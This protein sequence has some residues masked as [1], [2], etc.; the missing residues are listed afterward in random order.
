MDVDE[1]N[2]LLYKYHTSS[3]KICVE[4]CC[5]Y[6]FIFFLNEFQ[7]LND[8]Y[9]YVISFYS[10]IQEPIHLYID[11]DRKI[12]V[13][14]NNNIGVKN[15]ITEKNILSATGIDMPVFYKFYMDLCS[16]H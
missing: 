1:Y 3:L 4:K 2:I 16:I 12:E 7:N 11:Y 15:Y 6:K 8:L 9:N 10:H 5:G 13:P 14:N